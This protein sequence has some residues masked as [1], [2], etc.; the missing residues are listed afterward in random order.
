MNLYLISQEENNEYDTYDSAVVCAESEE[1]ARNI[2]PSIFGW[3]TSVIACT[4]WCTDPAQVT[5]KYLGEAH[6]DIERGSIICSSF[7][8][9]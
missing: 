9:S 6:T 7:N 5:V 2:N 1:E 4:A 8:G 3:P